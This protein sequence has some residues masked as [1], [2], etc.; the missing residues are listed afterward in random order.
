MEINK[1]TNIGELVA[2][3]Y[4]AATVFKSYGID[5]CCQGNRTLGD[6][7]KQKGIDPE[8]VIKDVVEKMQ[9]K[10]N[11]SIDFQS[12]PPDLLADY[13]EKTHH[14]YVTKSVEEIKPFLEK[15][16]SVHGENH[17]EL[18]E[19]HNFFGLRFEN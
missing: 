4:R 15:A 9:E 12:F 6:A 3:D 16:C 7:C 13:I 19:V 14:R 2:Q 17:P 11:Q 8:D 1:N 18:L 10:P 5:F